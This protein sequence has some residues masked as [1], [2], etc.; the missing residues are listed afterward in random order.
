MSIDEG[1]LD[2][3]GVWTEV[4]ARLSSHRASGRGH[5]LTEHTLRWETMAVLEARGIR[6]GRLVL[7]YRAPE[8]LGGSLDLVV[9]PPAGAVIEFKGIAQ[10]M[11]KGCSACTLATPR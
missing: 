6:P 8:L 1:R 4:A 10:V 11:L 2:W 5:L 3:V 9:D 7:E